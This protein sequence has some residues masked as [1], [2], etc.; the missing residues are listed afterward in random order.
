MWLIPFALSVAAAIVLSLAAITLQPN[1]P[2]YHRIFGGNRRSGQSD[3]L[4]YRRMRLLD[5]SGR[6]RFPPYCRY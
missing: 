1:S 4:L 3:L 2:T 5:L 6:I